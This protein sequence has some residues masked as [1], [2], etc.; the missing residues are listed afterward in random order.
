VK[1]YLRWV[2]GVVGL[3]LIMSACASAPAAKA[4]PTA[5][6]SLK[7]NLWMTYPA[8]RRE[9]IQSAN[10]VVYDLQGQPVADA[11]G[12]LV[13]A[14]GDYEQEYHFPLTNSKGW[15]CV[16]VDLPPNVDQQSV[17]AK[18][19]VVQSESGQWGEAQTEFEVIQ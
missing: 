14:V 19:I 12:I 6:P 16:T 9:Q 8:V 2:C 10:L 1:A 3:A 13:I 15:A 4:K 18:V 5:T 7:I 11:T 17:S